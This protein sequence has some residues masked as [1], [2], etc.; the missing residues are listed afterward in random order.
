MRRD[1]DDIQDELQVIRCLRGEQA[2]WRELVDRYTPRLRF[3]LKRLVNDADHVE[4]LLQEVW[5]ATLNGLARLRERGRL[6]PWLYGIAHRAAMTRLRRQYRQDSVPIPDGVNAVDPH[7][8]LAQ[9]R[10]ER[11]ELVHY[12]LSKLD[13]EERE[14]LTL[15]FLEELSVR[16]VADIVNVP[17]GTVKSRLFKARAD[18][19]RLLAGELGGRTEDV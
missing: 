18:L 5:L 6:S 16:E 7:S 12:G 9:L 1:A 2:A 13:L 11:I 17:E 4:S 19:R 8:E 10:Q 15:F 14:V 3:Y